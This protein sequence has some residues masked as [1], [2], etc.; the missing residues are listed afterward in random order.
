[1]FTKVDIIVDYCIKQDIMITGVYKMIKNQTQITLKSEVGSLIK[2]FRKNRK[3]T[4]NDLADYAGLS[5]A[6]IAKIEAGES[7]IKL[8]TLISI[9]NMLGLNLFL[10]ERNSK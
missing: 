4:Q 5:R 7:D 8:S 3:I 6:G 2:K 1:M 10:K 9:L